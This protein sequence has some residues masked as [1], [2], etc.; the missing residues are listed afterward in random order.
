MRTPCSQ[1]AFLTHE[2]RSTLHF[3][4]SLSLHLTSSTISPRG[5][6]NSPQL[7]LLRFVPMWRGPLLQPDLFIVFRLA[8]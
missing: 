1:D 3:P 4:G 5:F 6:A 8:L 7:A 2:A